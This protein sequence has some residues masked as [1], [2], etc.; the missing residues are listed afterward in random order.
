[1]K[2]PSR[3]MTLAESI[4][5]EHVEEGEVT[6]GQH[7]LVRV[8]FAMANDITAPMAIKNFEECGAKKIFDPQRIALV[9][10]H[11][12]PSKDIASAE[13]IKIL[14]QFA[15]KHSL[16]FFYEGGRAG[17]EHILVAEE[18]H[19][20]P[21]EVIVGADSHTCTLG[22]LGALALGVGSTDLAFAMIKGQI[23]LKV[24]QTIALIYY[25]KR[26]PWVS[27]KDLI[28]HTISDLGV[29]GALYQ[30]M[31]FMGEA[32]EELPMAERFT[33]C[34][35]A[36]EAG[37]KTGLI[38]V[39]EVT[40]RYLKGRSRRPFRIDKTSSH[41]SYGER[42]EYDVSQIPLMV[43][44]PSS[45]ANGVPVDELDGV[46]VDQVVI[47]SCTNGNL[48]DLKIAAHIMR[49]KKVHPSLRCI[50]IPATPRIYREALRQGFMEIFLEAE[51]VVS[52]PTCGPCLGG[53]MG[54]LASSEVALATTNRNFV[55][56]M[57]SE[58]SKVYLSGPAVAASTAVAG[59][60]CS[61]YHLSIKPPMK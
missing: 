7:L 36:V 34:N 29:D 19:A 11:F 37:A 5:A 52:P 61:P 1:M 39:D 30:V 50:I 4:L 33:L 60:I 12:A 51:A 9:A 42:R 59:K 53:H 27:G 28:L 40:L 41:G 20:L 44:V 31:E 21:G 58:K 22:A 10:D 56:R 48:E 57:G 55:G 35:M 47:G 3:G 26:K 25:G 14:R 38:R 16:P 17:I 46:H 15:M 6:P 2:A 18:G 24:P 32:I 45:P 49:G 43:A 8:D 54:V 13:Q 23:W